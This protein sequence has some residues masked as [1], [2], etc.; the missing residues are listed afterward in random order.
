MATDGNLIAPNDG[1]RRLSRAAIGMFALLLAAY[2]I[3]AMDRQLFPLLLSNV[4]KEYGFSLADAGFLSTV[5]TLGMAVAGLPTGYLLER[6][7]RKNIVLLGIALFSAATILTV[8][9][10]GFWDMLLYRAI[11]GLGEAMQLTA[12]LAIAAAYFSRYEGTA[13]GSGNFSFGIGAIVGPLLGGALLANT[14]NWRVPMIA[15]GI[16]G[17]IAIGL[18]ALAVRPWLSEAVAERRDAS[19]GSQGASTLA[20]RNTFL[21]ILACIFGGFV[22][23]GYLGMYPTFL[24]EQLGYTPG[25]AGSVMSF[26]G[27]GALLSLTGGWLGDRYSPRTVLSAAFVITGIVGYFMFHGGSAMWFQALLSLCWGLVASG[28]VYVN[29]AATHVKCV[30]GSLS[31][32][33]TGLFVTS[34]YGAA[35][36]SGYSFGWLVTHGSWGTAEVVQLTLLSLA[37]AAVSL[38]L[39]PETMATSGSQR[40]RMMRAAAHSQSSLPAAEEVSIA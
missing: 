1:E 23:Y 10:A 27:I 9:S 14:H 31:G 8:Y 30:R 11:T 24:R 37:G 12:L 17:F 33:A 7:S 4:R 15:Y 21:M 40:A 18:I 39:K 29:L 28:T 16:I 36:F 13:I 3:N 25:Q 20:N 2:A 5:F 32:R 19:V 35:A 6:F 38:A 26:Y 34:M 22:I